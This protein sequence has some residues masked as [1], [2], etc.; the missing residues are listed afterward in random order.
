MEAID[1][2]KPRLLRYGK[3][4]PYSDIRLP[5]GSG[6]DVFIQLNPEAAL[7]E[8]M[9]ERL[10]ERWPFHLR[11]DLKTGESA[12]EPAGGDSARSRREGDSFIRAYEPAVRCLV[13]GASP[14]ALALSELAA[15]AGFETEYY[16]PDPDAASSLPRA[17]KLWR[18][19]PRR[20]FAVDPWTA[21][22]LAFHDHDQEL[23]IFSELLRSP[24]FF[25]GAIGSKNAHAA[26]KLALAELGFSEAEIARIASPA[27]LVAGLKTA[28]FVTLSV[29]T[30]IVATARDKRIVA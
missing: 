12:L 20:P 28:P 4:S 9:S 16:T 27:G 17:V 1:T 2:G 18:I 11:V 7:I 5:C 8:E 14:I 24:C 15:C 21:A 26:R 30:Q 22:V 10:D 13:I 25:I 6:L 29:L 3:G 23:P 19:A